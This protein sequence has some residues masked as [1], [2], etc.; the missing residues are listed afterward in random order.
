[1]MLKTGMKV[2]ISPLAREIMRTRYSSGVEKYIGKT[3]TISY[4]GS[5]NSE[6]EE[7]CGSYIWKNEC[8]IP[9]S[10]FDVRA[11]IQMNGGIECAR[12]LKWILSI[13]P[14]ESITNCVSYSDGIDSVSFEMERGCD[15][16]KMVE[17]QFSILGK[18]KKI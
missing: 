3:A 18:S 17:K 14:T 5:E 7:D 16:R 13:V 15:I 4:A 11:T 10:V 6:I 1:M 12:I 2:R 8:F 9:L